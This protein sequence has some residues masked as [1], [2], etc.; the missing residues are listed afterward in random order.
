LIEILI[1]NRN[2]NLWDLSELVPE[3]TWKT[4]RIGKPGQVNMTI[5]RNPPY[6]QTRFEVNPGD[7]LRIVEDGRKVF[8]GYVFS[9]EETHERELQIVAYDQI[10]Y[11][12]EADTYV[13][14]NVTATQ[15]V[16]DNAEAVGLTLGALAETGYRIPKFLQ[17]GQK[18]IDIICAALDETLM[19]TG[20][21]Y[22]FYDDAGS[23]VLRDVEDM[24]I[25][26]VLGDDS[27][28]F[29]YSVKR[30]IDTDTYNRIKLV[31]D[32]KETGRREAYIVQ[33]SVNIARWGRLQYYQKVDDGLNPAQITAMAERLLQLKNRE[34]RR[35]TLEALGYPGVRAGMKLQVTIEELGVNQFFLV[36]ECT[37]EYK[38]DEHTMTLE[39]KVYG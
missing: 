24:A 36:E 2:G 22:V 34:Q 37:H 7:I 14:T 10:R 6:Q 5:V 11:L 26:L 16:R 27:L 21:L 3:F 33:D 38:G 13:R 25:D 19:A 9:I 12:I 1:D 32:N 31:K 30:E 29:G 8:L 15:V 20:R 17:D 35:F 4:S 18:R 39:L 28:V 23:L